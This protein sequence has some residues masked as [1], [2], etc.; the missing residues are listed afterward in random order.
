MNTPPASSTSASSTQEPRGVG[1][2]LLFLCITLVLVRPYFTYVNAREVLESVDRISTV[3]PS[4]RSYS[5]LLVGIDVVVALLALRAGLLL[6]NR[7]AKA[8]A[9]ARFALRAV[10]LGALLAVGVLASMPWPG[11]GREKAIEGAATPCAKEIAYALIWLS[12]L[13]R[14]RRV[15]NTFT[16]GA[17]PVTPATEGSQSSFPAYAAAPGSAHHS[18]T[19]DAT[20]SPTTPGTVAPW[21]RISEP[22]RGAFNLPLGPHP[23]RIGSSPECVIRVPTLAPHPPVLAEVALENGIVS[24]NNLVSRQTLALR[25]GS[26]L[27][28]G[29]LTVEIQCVA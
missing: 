12:Y 16:T 6:W 14:S 13:K 8:L 19:A 1:G 27:Q 18:G 7:S 10:A 11:A 25:H 2:W 4:W 5:Q 22:T 23:I 26:R 21:L 28:F 20:T 17:L 3:I 15:A 24:L 29:A 9:S